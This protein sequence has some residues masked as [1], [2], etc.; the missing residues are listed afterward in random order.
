[1]FSYSTQEL[2]DLLDLSQKGQTLYSNY[3]SIEQT[4]FLNPTKLVGDNPY[5]IEQNINDDFDYYSNQLEQ[6]K[7]LLEANRYEYKALRKAELEKQITNIKK[8]IEKI[9]A[10]ERE[11][12]SLISITK[13][14][15]SKFRKGELIQ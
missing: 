1:G 8:P 2:N 14:K 9:L 5:I 6:I 11:L 13:E 4:S 10:K 15:Y 12:S 3:K 7:K